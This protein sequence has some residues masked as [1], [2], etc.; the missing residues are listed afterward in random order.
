MLPQKSFISVSCNFNNLQN[1][2]VKKNLSKMLAL[3]FSFDWD[4]VQKHV[5][6]KALFED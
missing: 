3:S 6:A 1:F 2:V 5:I 4:P